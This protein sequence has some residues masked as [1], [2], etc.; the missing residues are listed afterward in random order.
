M[1][2]GHFGDPLSNFMAPLKK[3]TLEKSD[4]AM[5]LKFC[6]HIVCGKCYPTE[7]NFSVQACAQ[8]RAVCQRQLN[9]LFCVR[10]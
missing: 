4:E 6:M 10:Y 9:Y 3:K 2:E 1:I 8:L 7:A 5:H